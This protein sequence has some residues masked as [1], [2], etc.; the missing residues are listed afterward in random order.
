[1]GLE[2]VPSMH[3]NPCYSRTRFF[4]IVAVLTSATCVWQLSPATYGLAVNCRACRPTVVALEMYAVL[5]NPEEARSY[6]SVWDNNAIGTGHA[7]SMLHSPLAWVAISNTIG[8]HITI[9]LGSIQARPDD[10][11]HICTGTRPRLPKL[12]RHCTVPVLISDACPGWSVQTVAGVITQ[13]RAE[14]CPQWVSSYKVQRSQDC[15]TYIDVDGTE[16]LATARLA[17]TPAWIRFRQHRN[18]PRRAGLPHRW[19]IVWRE[20]RQPLESFE[21]LRRTRAG[22]AIHF[23]PFETSS[24]EN[25][26]AEFFA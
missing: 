12:H 7:R 6:S 1:M 3:R 20:F 25:F 15:T 19:E 13:G 4:L 16:R 14:C 9:S 10:S 22:N 21:L 2:C 8:Q 24:R 23:Q 26:P 11:R 5:N 18:S 17:T